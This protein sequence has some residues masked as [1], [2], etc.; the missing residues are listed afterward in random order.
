VNA[1]MYV[2]STGLPMAGVAEGFSAEK[3]GAA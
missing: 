2:L 3:H 1:I